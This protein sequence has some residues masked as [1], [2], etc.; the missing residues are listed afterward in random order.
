MPH[1]NNLFKREGQESLMAEA[2]AHARMSKSD[3]WL[4]LFRD[5]TVHIQVIIYK[6]TF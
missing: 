2:Q 1:A 6:V 4:S 5:S 3:Y